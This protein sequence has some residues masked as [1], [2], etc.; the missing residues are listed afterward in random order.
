MS[1]CMYLRMHVMFICVVYAILHDNSASGYQ[2]ALI[3]DQLNPNKKYLQMA[4]KLLHKNRFSIILPIVP[5]PDPPKGKWTACQ[6]QMKKHFN[7]FTGYDTDKISTFISSFKLPD[8][9]REYLLHKTV[10]S[11]LSDIVHSTSCL[12]EV[13][14]EVEVRFAI[15]DPLL[16]GITTSTQTKASLEQ[17]IQKSD[18]QL[19]A[20]REISQN[21]R[22]DYN[23]YTI[24][25]YYHFKVLILE[26]KVATL[27]EDAV[28]QMIGYY[29]AS[30][31]EPFHSITKK[32][33]LGVIISE[34]EIQFIFFPYCGNGDVVYINAVASTKFSI[35]HNT[36]LDNFI[37]ALAFIVLYIEG[38]DRC[39]TIDTSELQLH[40][41]LNYQQQIIPEKVVMQSLLRAQLERAE[42]EKQLLQQR[43][44][45]EK[46]QLQQ[47]AEKEK[48]R[49]EKEKQRRQQLEMFVRNQGLS[50]PAWKRSISETDEGV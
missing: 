29:M 22:A 14:Q 15:I 43:A 10:I 23:V 2:P 5:W 37:S 47:R 35:N 50:V 41:K 30:K 21:C 19:L 1:V 39:S 24:T 4:A 3:M 18:L 34:C 42:E 33:P 32:P 49:A 46:Q 31:V 44:E 25:D 38:L 28:C 48:E 7:S 11:V 12:T 6:L 45:E 36:N 27:T 26:A 16:K 13:L 9:F 17:S 8:N 40:A 20:T